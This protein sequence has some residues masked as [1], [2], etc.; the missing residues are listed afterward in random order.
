LRLVYGNDIESLDL[1]VGTHLEE[2]LPQSIFGETIYSV[3]VLHTTRR[4]SN[5]RFL[6]TDYNEQ[7]YTEWGMKHIFENTFKDLLV[8]HFPTLNSSIGENGFLLFH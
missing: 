1:L 8:R 7:Y 5:D 4:V 6:T 2:K 3:F